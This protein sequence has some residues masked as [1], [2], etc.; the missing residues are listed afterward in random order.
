MVPPIRESFTESDK[1]KSALIALGY[2]FPIQFNVPTPTVILVEIVPLFGTPKNWAGKTAGTVVLKV[3]GP[4]I[5]YPVPAT[6]EFDD[7]IDC[8]LLMVVL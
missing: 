5:I 4:L 6:I 1:N 2:G 7:G 3:C 8:Q